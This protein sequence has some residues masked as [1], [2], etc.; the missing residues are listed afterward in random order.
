MSMAFRS[1]SILFGLACL[2]YFPIQVCLRNCV[3]VCV[4]CSD[5][6]L[7]LLLTVTS[8]G[9][10]EFPNV[11]AITSS[12]G[13]PVLSLEEPLCF[14]CAFPIDFNIVPIP[15][16]TEWL[17]IASNGTSLPLTNTTTG[18][19]L[20]ETN[21]IILLISSSSV[22]LEFMTAQLRCSYLDVVQTNNI[23]IV[24]TSTLTLPGKSCLISEV[25]CILAWEWRARTHLVY[26]VCVWNVSHKR[27]YS[28]CLVCT[29][30]W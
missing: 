7:I 14:G 10:R 11:K 15:L 27:H 16:G 23:L 8:Q 22:G 6:G 1:P 4:R 19:T 17:V 12:G 25:I 13:I 29:I 30:G 3:C 2:L 26:I 24:L 18:V 28:A 21:G 9:L 20:S 5:S